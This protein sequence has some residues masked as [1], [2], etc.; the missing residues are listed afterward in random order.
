M[1]RRVRRRRPRQSGREERGAVAKEAPPHTAGGLMR[2]VVTVRVQ[3]GQGCGG[4]RGSAHARGL[5]RVVTRAR[6]PHER[7]E[8]PI[9]RV[10]RLACVCGG[11]CVASLRR[12]GRSVWA[13]GSAC[14]SVCGVECVAPGRS[15]PRACAADTPGEAPRAYMWCEP[16]RSSA[17]SLCPT[18]CV[19]PHKGGPVVWPETLG[20]RCRHASTYLHGRQHGL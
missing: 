16:P 4:V 9:E 8:A 3:A 19:R 2:G 1:Q 10:P 7:C 15:E 18:R 5:A 6:G 12:R 17:E 11:A 13:C 20:S 14:I